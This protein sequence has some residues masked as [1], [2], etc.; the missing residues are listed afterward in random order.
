MAGKV[1]AIPA[2]SAPY[3]CSTHCNAKITASF[4]AYGHSNVDMKF[5]ARLLQE[6][7]ASSTGVSSLLS[8]T[9]KAF[10]TIN[11]ELMWKVLSK[12]GC[13]PHFSKFS[14]NFMMAKVTVG[15]H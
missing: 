2:A 5:V 12:F 4:S 1:L 9:T 14:V 6:N 8:L 11:R 7:A 3:I 15:G 10:N 13:P